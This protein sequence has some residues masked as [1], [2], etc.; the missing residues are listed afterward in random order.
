M[1][2]TSENKR[3]IH[4]RILSGAADLFRENGVEAV[5]LDQIMAR[6]DLT[7]GAFYAHFN[8][9]GAL[10]AEVMRRE[11]PLLRMLEQ[12]QGQNAEDLLAEMLAI[13]RDYLDP[14]N[15]DRIW[16]GCSFASLTSE[17]ARADLAV[18]EGFEAAWEGAVTEMTRDQ[19]DAD[20]TRLR[21]ALL[22]ATSAVTTAAACK[23]ATQRATILNGASAQVAE[24]LASHVV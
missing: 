12:R 23:S 8:S 5:N 6:A 24:L 1:R 15:L 20:P 18:R 3:K 2:L 21:N 22:L 13:F 16:R 4:D 17:T 7:R 10:F 19:T 14:A 9:K 11:H